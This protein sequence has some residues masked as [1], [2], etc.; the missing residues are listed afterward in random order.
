[1]ALK[2]LDL[3]NYYEIKDK[4]ITEQFSSL[5]KDMK[6]EEKEIPYHSNYISY[7]LSRIYKLSDY[8]ISYFTRDYGEIVDDD[9][10]DY[11]DEIRIF[12]LT[13]DLEN[14]LIVCSENA[15]YGDTPLDIVANFAIKNNIASEREIMEEALELYDIR[16]NINKEIAK[17]KLFRYIVEKQKR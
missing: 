9:S 8:Q 15:N 2:E 3:T 6:E 12:G 7:S 5:L 14:L 16:F 4:L 10:T 1:M 13:M 17:Q 11:S